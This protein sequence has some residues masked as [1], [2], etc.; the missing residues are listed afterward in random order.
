[1][2]RVSNLQHQSHNVICLC[3]TSKLPIKK[4]KK[5]KKRKITKNKKKLP[6]MLYIALLSNNVR[7]QMTVAIFGRDYIVLQQMDICYYPEQFIWHNK[8]RQK[9]IY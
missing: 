8:I 2:A 6:I 9:S 4:K 3:Y 5:I 7:L 1:M